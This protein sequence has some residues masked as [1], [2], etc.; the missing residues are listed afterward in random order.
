VVVLLVALPAMEPIIRNPPTYR[1]QE[2]DT[3][4]D[5]LSARRRP[6]D[7]VYVWYRAV[8]NVAWYGPRHGLQAGDIAA[9]GCWMSEPRGFLRDIDRMRGRPRVWIE[10]KGSGISE[11]RMVLE[12]AG[13]IG[14]RGEGLSMPAS[15]PRYH[16]EAWLYDF[17][18]STRLAQASAD[19]F[20]VTL[21]T[22]ARAEVMACSAFFG[23]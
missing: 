2:T 4:L 19:S 16:L 17:S 14:L 21:R 13:R 3:L 5:W 23:T 8:P 12:Y 22:P 6:G 7:A 11:A 9:G 1:L 10:L 15:F 18:D 20:P